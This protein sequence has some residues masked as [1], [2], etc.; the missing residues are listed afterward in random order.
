MAT[1]PD[2]ILPKLVELATAHI[3][4]MALLAELELAIAGEERPEP[5]REATD[6]ILSQWMFIFSADDSPELGIEDAELL[7]AEIAVEVK[8]VQG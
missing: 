8:R 3:R 2:A 1:D 4:A 7:L 6:R 5:E